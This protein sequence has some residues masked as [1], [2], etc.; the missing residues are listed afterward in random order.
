[1]IIAPHQ[2]VDQGV[3]QHVRQVAAGSQYLVVLY[4]RHDQDVGAGRLPHGAHSRQR[5]RVGIVIRCQDH[6]MPLE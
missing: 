2:H 1:M 6:M 5:R 3:G 4:D